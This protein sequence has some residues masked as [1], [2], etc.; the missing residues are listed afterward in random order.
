MMALAAEYERRLQIQTPCIFDG[1]G[2]TKHRRA[3]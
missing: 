3:A 2:G 1:L